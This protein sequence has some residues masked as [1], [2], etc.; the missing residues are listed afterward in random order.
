MSDVI[1]TDSNEGM[2]WYLNPW[3][4]VETVFS[5][6]N[7]YTVYYYSMAWQELYQ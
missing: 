4:K 2:S 5:K 3:A 1:I 6:I 7:C